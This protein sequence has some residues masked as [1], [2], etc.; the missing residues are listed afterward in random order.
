MEGTLTRVLAIRTITFILSSRHRVI[1]YKYFKCDIRYTIRDRKK[2]LSLFSLY[3]DSRY[4]CL[5][6]NLICSNSAKSD[7]A[8]HIE[9]IELDYIPN[10]L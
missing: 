2:D 9:Y 10:I 7:R 5:F 6:L 8:L 4:R 3:T 1:S